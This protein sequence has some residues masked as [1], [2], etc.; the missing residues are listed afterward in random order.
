MMGTRPGG[1]EGFL[2]SLLGPP[3]SAGHC[4]GHSEQLMCCSLCPMLF[5]LFP[6]H[7]CSAL[8]RQPGD[9]PPAFRAYLGLS[10]TCICVYTWRLAHRA[11]AGPVDRSSS[12]P[13]LWPVPTSW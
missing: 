13:K 3:L 2:P 4:A 1:Q 10:E 9:S 5:L 11:V 8:L 12:I 7:S 6:A